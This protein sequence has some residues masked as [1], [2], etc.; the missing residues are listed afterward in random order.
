MSASHRGDIAAG[1]P[2]GQWVPSGVLPEL[3]LLNTHQWWHL[4][5]RSWLAAPSIAP[6]SSPVTQDPMD[7]TPILAC[8]W[9][10]IPAVLGKGR[11]RT[12]TRELPA[13]CWLW[14]SMGAGPGPAPAVLHPGAPRSEPTDKG[15]L[16]A[17]G[18]GA[19]VAAVPDTSLLLGGPSSFVSFEIILLPGKSGRDAVHAAPPHR[20]G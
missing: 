17:A 4:S 10:W 9:L 1:W 8:T 11:G 15:S 2:W 6:L 13:R 20:C 18:C 3:S 5:L 12:L 16:C 19:L 7:G 14:H